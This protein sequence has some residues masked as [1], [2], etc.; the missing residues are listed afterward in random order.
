MSVYNIFDFYW[1]DK[2]SGITQDQAGF[3]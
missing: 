2:L 1:L 3:P